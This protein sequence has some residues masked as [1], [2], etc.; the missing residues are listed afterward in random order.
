MNIVN[1]TFFG[2][3][4]LF[5][6]VMVGGLAWTGGR[7]VYKQ[8][9]SQ[10]YPV[11]TGV[12][13]HSEVATHTSSK[14][15]TSYSA[16]V[17]YSF[18]VN[19]K[20]QTGKKV[21]YVNPPSGAAAEQFV[22]EHPNKSS[23]AVYYNP[24]DPSDSVLLPG[25]KGIDLMLG[26]FVAPFLAITAGLWLWLT[27]SL[28]YWIFRP[29]AGGVK[30]IREGLRVRARLPEAGAALYWLVATGGIG[31]IMVFVVG[32]GTRMDPPVP[33]M[34]V[35][36]AVV[37]LSG[38]AACLWRGRKLSAGLYDLVVD[39]GAR[40]VELPAT[41]GRKQRETISIDNVAGVEVKQERHV[42]SK[43]AVSYT[44]DPTL[45]IRCPAEEQKLAAWPGRLRAEDFAAW[46]RK[47]LGM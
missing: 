22:A 21:R 18:A 29:A 43:G 7:D 4:A 13:E 10:S 25:V 34:T 11:A 26:V 19:D 6:S 39:E 17:T 1:A 38:P 28:R 24:A 37:Y 3:F 8:F 41:K 40:T 23:V 46:L 2:A 33:L 36:I 47:E 9:V 32:F 14:N 15:G 12:V 27:S 35:V 5:W 30:I 20:V 31:F 16:S 42:T 45:I 44:Y